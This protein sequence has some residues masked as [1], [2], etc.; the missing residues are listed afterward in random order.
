MIRRAYKIA[1]SDILVS[2]RSSCR[3]ALPVLLALL[4]LLAAALA[5]AA[6][7]SEAPQSAAAVILLIGDGM[8]E[9]QRTAARWSSVGSSGD[10]SMDLLEIQ[11]GWLKTA[12][13]FG[14]VTDSA[15]AATAMATGRKTLNGRIGMDRDGNPL[16]TILELARDAGKATGLITT[17]QLTHATPAAFAA[18]VPTRSMRS[19]IASQMIEARVDVLLGGGEDDF[20]PLGTTGCHPG[21][22]SRLDG[23]N[24]VDEAREHGTA[25]VCTW[26]DL[27]TATWTDEP[28]R[29]VLGLFADSALPEPS[30]PSLAEMTQAALEALSKDADGFFL[31]VEG[32]QIDWECHDSDAAGAIASTLSFDAAVAVAI[33]FAEGYPD[34]LVIV[35]ADHETGGMELHTEATGRRGEDGPFSMPDGTA[36]YVTWTTDGHTATDVRVSASGPMADRLLGTHGNTYLFTVMAE[37]LGIRVADAP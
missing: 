36:F 6:G 26:D 11:D 25:I 18:H 22:G 14:V 23:R 19:T 17:V 2:S 13:A 34:T 4:A 29:P 1:T 5:P 3:R 37:A 27:Q 24:L 8:G 9:A 16:P 28:A 33:D 7:T 30:T 21:H 10:L 15:A 35:T 20:L 12:P 32:G 31:M